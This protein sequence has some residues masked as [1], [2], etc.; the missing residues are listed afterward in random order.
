MKQALEEAQR[1]VEEYRGSRGKLTH[2]YSPLIFGKCVKNIPL[3]KRYPYTYKTIKLDT[4]SLTLYKI[5]SKW[6]KDLKMCL[7]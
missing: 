3:E 1:P 4:V 5:N 7:L 2:S 6:F